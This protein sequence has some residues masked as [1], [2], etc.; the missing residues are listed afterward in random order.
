MVTSRQ[1][2][3]IY[4]MIL[5]ALKENY[6]HYCQEKMTKAPQQTQCCMML[7]S[8]EEFPSLRR[9]NPQE[10]TVMKPFI[11]SREMTAE[12]SKKPI[13]QAEEVLNWQSKNALA[14]NSLLQKI[15]RKM[16]KIELSIEKEIG[17]M[18]SRLQ[19]HYTELKEKRERLEEETRK[20]KE[21]RRFNNL[22][23]EKERELQKT[24][25]NMKNLSTM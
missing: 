2:L 10:E 8:E 5:K 15:E 18:N 6:E 7:S 24:R 12:G 11:Y 23:I 1:P 17:G 4:E 14:Q 13:S 16:D 22:L 20:I 21:T 9:A 3:P 25:D 19:K